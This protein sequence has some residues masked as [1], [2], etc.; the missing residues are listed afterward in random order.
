MVFRHVTSD[1][2]MCTTNLK[3]LIDVCHRVVVFKGTQSLRKE[4]DGL[5]SSSVQK[6]LLIWR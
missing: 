6:E 2:T 4:G 5:E 1:K 3:F